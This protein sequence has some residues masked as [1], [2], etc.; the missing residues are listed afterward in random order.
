MTENLLARE[1]S[2]YLLQHKDNPVHWRPWGA[3]ALAEARA[4]DKP[5]LLSIGYAACHWCHVMAHESFENPDIAGLM[6]RH[7]VNIK[8]DREERPDLD[9]IYQHA[10]AMM[11]EH[12]GWP[13]TMFLTPDLEPFWG[14]TYFPPAPRYGRPGF[15]QVLQSLAATYAGEPEKIADNA[16]RMRD[17][18]ATLEAPAAG[19]A[20]TPAALDDVSARMLRHVD[21]VHGGTHGAPK[22]PQV[23][24]FQALWRAYLR[25]RG[26]MYREAVT[27]TLANICQGGIYDHL[28]GGFARYA[29]DAEWLV[30]HFE[31]MLYDN[32]LLVELMTEVRPQL[33]PGPMADL[34]RQR[35]AETVAWMLADMRSADDPAAPFAFTSAYDADS[36]GDEGKYYVWTAAEIDALLGA[37]ADTFKAAYDVTPGG[38]WEGRNILNRSGDAAF[39]DPDREALLA[40][41]RE[42][43]LS[44]RARRVP[45]LRDD[46]V[47][48]D[49]NG[50]A[51][52]ALAKAAAVFDRPDWLDTA[53]RVFAF[54]LDNLAAASGRL[55]HTWCAGRAAHPGVLD[56]YANLAR[57]ALALHQG[58]GAAAYL[59]QAETLTAVL[60]RHFRDAAGGGY[61]MA[62]DDTPH[63]LTR[64][65]PVHD[66]AVPCGNGTMVEVLARLHHLT[67]DAAYRDRAD[68]LIAALAPQES[69]HLALQP[70]FLTGFEILEN[71]VQVTVAGTGDGAAALVT[72]A[73]ASG[74]PRLVLTRT[75]DGADLPPGHPAAG[76]GPAD[77]RPAAYLC[78]GNTCSLPVTDP[79]ALA[80]ALKDQR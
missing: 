4:A 8:V 64:S 58:T 20:I 21:P 1:T 10:L 55:H 19:G 46:K 25:T 68:A 48:A 12:G 71:A 50:L 59:R 75:A 34:L 73:L 14:G 60:D 70:T 2:P 61:F 67:G 26:A 9:N 17:A 43:L 5:I 52:A 77:G 7:F 76:K 78:V 66:N 37:D 29:V 32:A 6:N 57:A 18:L 40:R 15:P 49:W 42:R 35:T 16:R 36:E 39:G 24:F 28:G 51:V 23:N 22:F 63:L 47:L 65:K 54:I 72:A 53:E 62:A 45:P 27:A 69:A 41:C 80:Q 79:A 33:D 31:K 38:N 11:G 3:D 30:P 56:D 44:H 13:L 74:H